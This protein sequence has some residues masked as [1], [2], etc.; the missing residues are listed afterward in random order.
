[1]RKYFDCAVDVKLSNQ[2]FFKNYRI[3]Y[4]LQVAYTWFW[5]RS[6]FCLSSETFVERRWPRMSRRIQTMGRLHSNSYK[7]MQA[8]VCKSV[9][10]FR[11]IHQCIHS[12]IL[13]PLLHYSYY[14]INHVYHFISN[15]IFLQNK[16]TVELNLHSLL[17]NSFTV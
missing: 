11:E 10:C 16:N 4:I 1:M 15:M 3:E 8:L 2:S 7:N 9:K 6:L 14:Y 12:N 13:I 17:F 5:C